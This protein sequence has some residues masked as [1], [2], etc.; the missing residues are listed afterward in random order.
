[1]VE[2]LISRYKIPKNSSQE[3]KNNNKTS[4]WLMCHKKIIPHIF[5]TESLSKPSHYKPSSRNPR[6]NA[7]YIRLVWEKIYKSE[8]SN[9][10]PGWTREAK[11]VASSAP[12]GSLGSSGAVVRWAMTYMYPKQYMGSIPYYGPRC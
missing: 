8:G 3:Q 10:S 4:N 6:L 1:M 5:K 7:L 9:L 11:T 2:L 12:S